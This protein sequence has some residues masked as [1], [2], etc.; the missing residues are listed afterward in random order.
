MARMSIM[1]D[2]F[3]DLAEMVDNVNPSALKP[4][5]EK[6]LTETAKYVQSNVDDAA[7]PYANK[8]GGLK[9]YA[10]GAMYNALKKENPVTWKTPFIAEVS[11]GF[12]LHAKGGFHS[13]FVMYG[14]PR[15]A[16]DPKLYNS[17]KGTKTKKE[18]AKIQEDILSVEF[19]KAVKG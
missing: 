11:V 10:T 14:T 6:A 15:M 17:I 19:Y 12:N 5:V 1:F 13:I 18:V 16:K 3:K 4:A 2:G 7:L 9:G 8:G